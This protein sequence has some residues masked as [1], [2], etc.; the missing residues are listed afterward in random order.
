M[1]WSLQELS[2]REAIRQVLST[3]TRAINRKDKDL[4][5][6]IFHIDGE[7]D[8]GT[9][10]GTA[11]DFPSW[12]IDYMDRLFEFTAQ[13]TGSVVIDLQGDRAETESFASV[14]H[15]IKAVDDEGRQFDVLFCRYLDTLEKRDGQWKILKRELAMDWRF[16]GPLGT[17]EAFPE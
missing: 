7:D 3:Y 4:L 14:V 15:V 1:T 9:F 2:D 10:R 8:H 13:C 16:R 11:A 6:S 17:M 12:A 5:A